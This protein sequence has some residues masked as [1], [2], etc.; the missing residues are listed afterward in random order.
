MV[1]WRGLNVSVSSFSGTV[2]FSG[3]KDILINCILSSASIFNVLVICI[4][5]S[6]YVHIYMKFVQVDVFRSSGGEEASMSDQNSTQISILPYPTTSDP[7][8]WKV[9]W[10]AQ[11]Q[12]WRTEPEI[13]VERQRYLAERR[14][15]TP[16]WEQG[17]FPFRSI[18]LNRADV[19]WL[20]ATLDNGRGPVDWNDE[21]QRE[22]EGLDLRGADLDQADL[23]S[24]PL[25]SMQAGLTGT[26]WYLASL[27][28]VKMAAIQMEGTRLVQTYL[29]GAK[30]NF[31]NL[32]KANLKGADLTSAELMNATLEEAYLSE[33]IL[34]GATFK[35]AHLE[36]ASLRRAHLDGISTPPADLRGALFDRAT[37]FK[38]TILGNK[39][40]GYVRL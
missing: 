5:I 32:R 25:A 1:N 6:S 7:E 16:D 4:G 8:A 35:Y 9:Y 28:Q 33:A 31:G 11:N 40:H 20:L 19:E 30:L 3:I 22:R 23:S 13:D 21:S 15:I 14:N 34:R 39:E 29:E 10:Q 18:K 38:G 27:E 24:L 26:V 36:G 17:I 12:P 2:K 37:S